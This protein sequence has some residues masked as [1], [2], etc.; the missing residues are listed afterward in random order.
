IAYAK[1]T[2]QIS[3]TLQNTGKKTVHSVTGIA[4]DSFGKIGKETGFADALADFS[5]SLQKQV[6]AV[7]RNAGNLGGGGE[8]GGKGV[9]GLRRAG[10][11]RTEETAGMTAGRAR[12]GH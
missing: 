7:G 9:P 11:G 3:E 12:R 10:G 1:K 5:R 4:E 6:T 8:T 2:E